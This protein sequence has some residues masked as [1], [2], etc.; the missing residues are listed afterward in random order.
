MDQ[1]QTVITLILSSSVFILQKLA[2]LLPFQN[3]A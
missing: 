3:M 1:N 2:L